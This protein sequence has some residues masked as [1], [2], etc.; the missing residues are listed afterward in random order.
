MFHIFRWRRERR[1]A[2]T[3]PVDVLTAQDHKKGHARRH[4]LR[5]YQGAHSIERLFHVRRHRSPTDQEKH[6]V[7]KKINNHLLF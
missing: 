1:N 2:N 4:R 5:V 7:I 3:T 6:Q